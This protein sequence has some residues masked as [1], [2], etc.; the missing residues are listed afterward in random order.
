MTESEQTNFR[1]AVLGT[2]SQS[3]HS[4]LNLFPRYRQGIKKKKITLLVAKEM[5]L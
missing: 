4:F 5:A 1:Q 3:M 2:G